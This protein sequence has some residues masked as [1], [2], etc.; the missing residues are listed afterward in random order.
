[1]KKGLKL[2]LSIVSASL[3]ISGC[4]GGD[5]DGSSAFFD[6]ADL[7]PVTVKS[8]KEV[9]KNVATGKSSSGLGKFSIDSSDSEKVITDA[10]SNTALLSTLMVQMAKDNTKYTPYSLNQAIDNESRCTDGGSIRVSG[11]GNQNEMHILGSYKDCKI[12]SNTFNGSMKIDIKMKNSRTMEYMNLNFPSDFEA[13]TGLQKIRYFKNSKIEM[14]NISGSSFDMLTTLKVDVDGRL[15]GS[16]NSKWHFDGDSMYQVSGK[17]YIDN[18]GSY[19]TYDKGYDMSKTPFRYDYKGIKSGEAH[20]VGANGGKI[21][22]K[23]EDGDLLVKVDSDNNGDFETQE[24][25]SY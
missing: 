16:D 5:S 22:L 9:A 1:M 4:G 3:L 17:E 6:K 14:N 19:V 7:A 24:R 11:D 15:H 20:Y 18:L 2:G 25:V 21:V 12:G 23:A 13:S 8:G 10:S